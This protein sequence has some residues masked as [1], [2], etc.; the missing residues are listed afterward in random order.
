MANP[1]S[2]LAIAIKNLKTKFLYAGGEEAGGRK[3][4]ILLEGFQASPVRP[5]GS[6]SVKINV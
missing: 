2:I 1:G 3:S 4:I 6:S 5:S